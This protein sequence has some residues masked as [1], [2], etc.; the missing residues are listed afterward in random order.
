MSTNAM[1]ALKI[2]LTRQPLSIEQFSHLCACTQVASSDAEIGARPRS[3]W[4][5]TAIG[6]RVTLAIADQSLR[7][8]AVVSASH[9]DLTRD[10]W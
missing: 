2:A 6:P 1:S 7:V 3:D 8:R 5:A 10:Y 9:C 4:L